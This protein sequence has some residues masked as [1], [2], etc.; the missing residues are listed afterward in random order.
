[1]G[2]T[3]S[4]T[5]ADHHGTLAGRMRE[6]PAERPWCEFWLFV[7]LT[8]SGGLKSVTSGHRFPCGK[9]YVE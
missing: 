7:S 8:I 3:Q 2:V 5:T 9:F 6:E 4:R 1:M